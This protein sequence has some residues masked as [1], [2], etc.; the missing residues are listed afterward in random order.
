MSHESV[1]DLWAANIAN[2]SPTLIAVSVLFHSISTIFFAARIT[3]R[4]KHRQKGW[5]DF[6][7]TVAWIT[8]FVQT[9]FGAMA[10]HYGF[11]KHRIDIVTTFSRAMFYFYLYQ[12]CYMVLGVFT[13]LTFCFLYLR[14]F[15]THQR[16]RKVVWWTTGLIVVGGSAFTLA[17]VWQCTPIKRAWSMMVNGTCTDKMAFWYSHAAFNTLLDIVVSKV[18][19][20]NTSITSFTN[21]NTGLH[22]PYSAH[23]HSPNGSQV[24]TQPHVPLLFRSLR[25]RSL[26]ST[27]GLP[28]AV[29]AKQQRRYLG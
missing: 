12:I 14:L 4:I 23:R 22:P 26:H 27:H 17:T 7:A 28:Q 9:T 16:F 6:M 8:L 11:G 24:K 1:P 5:D 10:A 13:K 3:W 20:I 18:L 29:R 19:L 2:Q 21:S 25:S 15:H